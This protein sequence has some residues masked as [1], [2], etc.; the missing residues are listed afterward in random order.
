MSCKIKITM[1]CPVLAQHA[2]MSPLSILDI[3]IT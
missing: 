2:L 1:S 3:K